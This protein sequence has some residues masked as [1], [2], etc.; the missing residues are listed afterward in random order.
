MKECPADELAPVPSEL[1]HIR[2]ELVSWDLKEILWL[3]V[4]DYAIGLFAEEVFPFA[5]GGTDLHVTPDA[6]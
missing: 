3:R 2:D 6:E 1:K 5:G 4:G